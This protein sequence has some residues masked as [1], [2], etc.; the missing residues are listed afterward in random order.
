MI[1]PN[2]QLVEMLNSL[3]ELGDATTIPQLES[4]IELTAKNIGNDLLRIRGITMLKRSSTAAA[5]M[6][7]SVAMRRIAEQAGI[8]LERFD[9]DVRVVL[10]AWSSM[11]STGYSAVPILREL[12]RMSKKQLGY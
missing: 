11:Y 2:P 9:E 4:Q 3:S 6:Q 8:N 7:D 1:A 5:L 12:Q 10:N